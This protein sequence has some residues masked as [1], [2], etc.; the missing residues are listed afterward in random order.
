MEKF[1]SILLLPLSFLLLSSCS[2]DA[3]QDK[4]MLEGEHGFDFRESRAAWKELKR[5]N[6]DSYLYSI[7]EQSW[8]G[9][10]SETTIEVEKGKVKRRYFIAFVISE[11]DGSKEITDRYEETTKK[12]IG[13]HSLGAPPYTIDDLY[14]TCISKY[15]TVDHDANEVF[16]ETTEEGLMILCGFVPIGCQDDCYRGIRISHFEWK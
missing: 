14:H 9:V 3:M 1:Y 8:T 5:Q 16:F 6:G 4:L 12:E 10:G 7:L 15:L 2:V 11:V 13:K